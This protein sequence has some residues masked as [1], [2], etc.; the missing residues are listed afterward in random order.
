MKTS[1]HILT[2][3]LLPLLACAAYAESPQET[4]QRVNA[5]AIQAFPGGTR[6][7][8]LFWIASETS[9]ETVKSLTGLVA[10]AKRQN[11]RWVVA[12]DDAVAVKSTLLSAFEAS[13]SS[14]RIRT[15]IVL[16]SPLS[17]DQE[18]VDAAKKVGAS[19]EFFVL[20]PPPADSGA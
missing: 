11:A 12:S 10:A 19:L 13:S 18:L 15:E 17:G 2:L 20:P 4:Y 5:V 9:A 16:V 6:G 7:Y 1:R 14:R 3:L 8:E